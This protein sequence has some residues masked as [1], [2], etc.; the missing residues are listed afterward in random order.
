MSSLFPTAQRLISK[1]VSISLLVL[2]FSVLLTGPIHTSIAAPI[3]PT[4]ST[5]IFLGIY[6]QGWIDQNLINTELISLDTWSGKKTSMA[7]ISLEVDDPDLTF[8]QRLSLL[9]NNGYTPF[10]NIQT[11]YFSQPTMYQIAAGAYDAAI[12]QWASTYAAWAKNGKWAFISVFPEMNI[13]WVSYGRDPGN[14]KLAFVRIRQLFA[15]SGVPDSAVRW[16]FSPNGWV[17]S[18]FEA[19]YPGDQWVD[20]LGFVTFHQGY[21][22][23]ALDPYWETP[24][25]SIGFS[26]QELHD[27]APTKPVFLTRFGVSAYDA[28]SH[29]S[30]AAKN[31]WLSDAYSYV[32][33]YPFVRGI[34]YYNFRQTSSDCDWAVYKASAPAIGYDGYKQAISDS[35]F[36]YLTPAQLG[37]TD[38]S[39]HPGNEKEF[40]PLAI[41]TSPQPVLLGTYSEEWIGSQRVMDSEYHALDAW[42]GKRLSLAGLF[43][44]IFLDPVGNFE[45]PLETAWDNGYT[46]F[47]NLTVAYNSGI[48]SKMIANGY[49]DAKLH[50]LAKVY[51]NMVNYNHRMAF[52]APL[53]E[54]NGDWVPYGTHPADYI[55]AYQRFQQ[56]FAD[57]GVPRESIK[58]VFAPNGASSAGDPRFESYYPGD[59]IVDVV[60]FSSYQFGYCPSAGNKVW[61]TLDNLFG[62]YLR[63]MTAMAPTKPIFIAQTATTA[64]TKHGKDV[65]AKNQWLVDMYN[66]LANY[67]S[68]RGIMYFNSMNADCDWSFYQQGGAQYIGYYWGVANPVYGYVSPF[69]LKNMVFSWP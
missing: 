42:A 52:F 62:Q 7:G 56:I 34:L 30:D 2:I 59:A 58:W 54:M 64:M 33:G 57:E 53:Q 63:R 12:T 23:I 1:K 31:Q 6:P 29:T 44:D 16:V 15:Q 40:L 60:G 61:D 18:P 68:V 49:A 20:V 19:Y 41:Q 3:S 32:A 25:K 55:Q 51:A 28:P 45:T 43:V 38:L 4:S 48:T 47:V 9:W 22:P 13:S 46:P 69:A 21:C 17:Q 10:I 14:Y 67:P 8:G 27:L 37:Q 26:L 65:N 35:H 5:P 11:G 24:D 36:G 66:Y 50:A 39:I